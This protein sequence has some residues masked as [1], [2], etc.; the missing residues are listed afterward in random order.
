[1]SQQEDT[2]ANQGISN[3]A[4]FFCEADILVSHFHAKN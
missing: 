2:G 4:K 3:N 1:M